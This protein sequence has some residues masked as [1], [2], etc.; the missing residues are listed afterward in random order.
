MYAASIMKK[1]L[2]S[3][4][5][6]TIF[7]LYALHVRA[8]GRAETVAVTPPSNL[9][10]SNRQSSFTTPVQNTTTSS[11]STPV[12]QNGMMG[13]SNMGMGMMSKYKDGTYTG[14]VADAFYGYV[15]VKVTIS[16]GKI[17]DVQFLQYPNDRQTSVYI[18]SQA[19]PYLKQEA[20]AAQSANVAGV[21]GATQTSR[22]F[23]ESL[24]SALNKAS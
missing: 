9:N 1:F 11:G 23:I 5:V 8:E 4:G 18:N 22:A 16:G 19:I 7:L 21:S 20:I 12:P 15:Q 24:Q 17:T 2:L 6:I 14:D 10:E 13:G 3:G